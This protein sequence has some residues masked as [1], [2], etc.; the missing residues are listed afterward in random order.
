MMRLCLWFLLFTFLV[1][2]CLF[3]EVPK[4]I[5]G[6]WIDVRSIPETEEGIRSLVDH[7]HEAHFNALFVESFYRGET[8][9]PSFF[10]ASQGLPSQMERFRTSG[11][12]PLQVI[13][14]EAKKR[15]MQVHAWYDLFYVGLDEPGPILSAF[16]Q[17]A[18]RNRDGTAGYV[19]GG[20]RFF[21]VCPMHEG[22]LEFYTGLLEEVVKKYDLDGLHFDYF[23]FP[24][25][26]IADTCYCENCREKFRKAHSLDPLSLDPIGDFK[27]Y[28]A[29]VAF[30]AESLSRFAASLAQHIR[31]VRPDVLLSCA[32]KPFGF[33]LLGYPGFL[34]DWP[35]WGKAKIFDFLVPMTYS[36]R[37]AEFEGLLIWVRTFLR[38]IPFCAGIWCAGMEKEKILEEIARARRHTPCGVVLFALPYLSEDLLGSVFEEFLSPPSKEDFPNLLALPLSPQEFLSR[39]RTIVARRTEL[40]VTLDGFLEDLWR[41]AEWQGDFVS[42]LGE[43]AKRGTQV[44][45][46]YD[47]DNLYVACL[48]EGPFAPGRITAQDGPVFY[49]DSVE[50]FL[51]PWMSRSFFFQFATNSL[52]TQYDGSS[53]LGAR[54][55]GLWKVGVGEGN[56]KTVVEMAIPFATL[57]RGTPKEG[58]TWGVNFCRNSI[59]EGEFSTWSPMP[60]VYGASFFFGN[61]EFRP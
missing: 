37:P 6:V 53:L 33:P 42:I 50:L 46:L 11:I 51:D 24:D 5:R 40:P 2:P 56:G 16:P 23:R 9:Y 15:N 25:P 29:W 52:G 49:D 20:K 12:D 35:A 31:K 55:G 4:E 34:Q 36:S 28:S 45:C 61:L 3:A 7:L 60:G 38:D 21:F 17:W 8:I 47:Q 32:V 18:G 1:G 44:A 41:N 13:I 43:K 54:F 58:E 14:D 39:R 30:R 48:L 26:T 57:S 27:T 10:L 59:A 22:V 19:Q